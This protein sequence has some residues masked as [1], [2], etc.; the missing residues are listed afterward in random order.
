M[1]Q[2]GGCVHH[3]YMQNA[4]RITWLENG[5]RRSAILDVTE[6]SKHRLIGFELNREGERI[7]PKG[8]DVRM[9]VFAKSAIVRR[10][11]MVIN[12]HYGRLEVTP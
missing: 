11:P 8:F 7:S 6:E 3:L 2:G 5:R 4:E 10:Q 12:L 9:R 1:T